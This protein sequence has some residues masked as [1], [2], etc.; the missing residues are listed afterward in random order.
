MDL[1]YTIISNVINL[2]IYLYPL[3]VQEDQLYIVTKYNNE[4]I[5][6]LDI[7]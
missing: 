7:H 1:M 6:F 4:P 2:F 5:F 3:Y